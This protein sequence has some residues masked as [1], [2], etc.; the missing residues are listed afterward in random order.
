MITYSRRSDQSPGSQSAAGAADLVEEGPRGY[1]PYG[2]E[3]TYPG[4]RMM[5]NLPCNRIL[6][7][8]SS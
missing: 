2:D 7:R 8:N 4:H 1:R 3:A 5:R 6:R